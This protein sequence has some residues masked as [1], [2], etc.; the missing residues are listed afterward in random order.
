MREV[1]EIT[2]RRLHHQGE[3]AGDGPGVVALNSEQAAGGQAG[4]SVWSF[5]WRASY[6]LGGGPRGISY[7]FG[8]RAANW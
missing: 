6:H 3:P 2:P 4:P 5:T 8:G 7:A 1:G